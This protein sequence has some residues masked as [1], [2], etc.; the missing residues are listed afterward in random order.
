MRLDEIEKR[1][2]CLE[3]KEDIA[4]TIHRYATA[5]DY[6]HTDDW[7][8][9]FTED[10]V[11]EVR[12]PVAAPLVFAGRDELARMVGGHTKAPGRWHKHFTTQL[13]IQVSG[14]EAFSQAYIVR[15]D[16]DDEDKDIPKVWVFGRYLDR[17]R[18]CDDDRWRFVHRMIEIEGIHPGQVSPIQELSAS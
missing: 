1:L 11:F 2:A 7:V 14:N 3:A 18:L 5:I 15:I 8:D 12:S 13:D 16:R 10:G 17:L 9:C 6:G 4:R